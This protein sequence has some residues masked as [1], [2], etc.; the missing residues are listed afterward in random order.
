MQASIRTVTAR[1]DVTDQ[2]AAA[3][4]VADRD[5][6][7]HGLHTRG[8]V[9]GVAEREH[10]AV[11]DDAGERHDA[12]GHGEDRRLRGCRQVQAPVARGVVGGG[13]HE[14]GHD[15]VRRGQRPGPRRRQR[16]ADGDEGGGRKRGGG[17]HSGEQHASTVRESPPR[18]ARSGAS[19]HT[20]ATVR[21]VG[22][23]CRDRGAPAPLRL[24]LNSSKQRFV[25]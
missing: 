20:S 1:G 8:Q 23:P 3:D 15:R 2:L 17:E 7:D 16:H 24:V 22:G 10:G 6:R 11:D 18:S 4:L 19:V 14:L 25:R 13:R 12:V 21:A 9:T 5:D